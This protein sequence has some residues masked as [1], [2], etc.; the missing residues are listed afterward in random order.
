VTRLQLGGERGYGWG[1][2]EQAR[3]PTPATD[4]FGYVTGLEGDEPTVTVPAG[5]QLLAHTVVQGVE[6]QGEI[7]PLVGREWGDGK[8][9][10][11]AG[12]QVVFT[13]LCYLP[14]ALVSQ[15]TTFRVGPYGIWEAV[16]AE[17]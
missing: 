16:S 3:S 8:E 15:N 13:N 10:Q 6:A 1:W 5:K 17:S 14:G 12:Q 2:V 7:E 4:L 9:G 11:G